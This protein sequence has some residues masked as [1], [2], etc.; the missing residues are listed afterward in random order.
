M[1]N[2][3]AFHKSL[4]ISICAV[5]FLI[6]VGGLV[7]S[8]GAGM[9]CPDWP[10]C[11]GQWVPPTEVS[12][13][14]SNY[15]EIFKVQGKEI[16]DFNAFKTWTEYIN[17]L[18]G[19]IIGFCVLGVF[20]TSFSY[21]KER[22]EI[23]I[24]SF[25]TLIVLGFQGW[26][27]SVVVSTNL[28]QW[29]ITIHMLVAFFIVFLLF[30]LWHRTRLYKLHESLKNKAPEKNGPLWSSTQALVLITLFMTLIQVVLGTQTREE[31]NLVQTAVPLISRSEW[32]NNLGI[33]FTIHRSFSIVVLG[34]HVAL[35]FYLRNVA[36]REEAL[37]NKAL[38]YTVSLEVISGIGMA[39]FGIPAYLQP[40]HLLFA[41]FMV[42]LLFY[43]SLSI[44]YQHLTKI[45]LKA[46]TEEP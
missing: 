10:K 17:R 33:F 19:V 20:V 35:F 13:L 12:E 5:Y 21:V 31:V 40:I 46:M 44:P 8:T 24:L 15:K 27:G 2:K 25:F 1:K 39:Y 38:L 26:L 45:S 43:L 4:V 32:V 41:S 28:A 18:I 9:G 42:G 34:C 37:F 6:F 14:P 7:R 16:A 11:F 23:P 36:L 30:Y 22:K 29:M 3:E